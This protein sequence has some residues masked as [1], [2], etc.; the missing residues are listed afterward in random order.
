[1]PK[2]RIS[3]Q[4]LFKSLHPV[5]PIVPR[6]VRQV[7][8]AVQEL[9]H[10]AGD[11]DPIMD[12]FLLERDDHQSSC[13]DVSVRRT[14]TACLFDFAMPIRSG[15]CSRGSPTILCTLYRAR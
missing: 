3:G 2:R 13:A 7:Q 9:L 1:V 4:R 10:E 15:C 12:F 11:L 8:S 6:F 5:I 14:V